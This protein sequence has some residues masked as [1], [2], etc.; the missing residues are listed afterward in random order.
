M[1][2]VRL[3]VRSCSACGHDHVDLSFYCFPN[4]PLWVNSSPYYW[5][6]ICP[7]TGETIVSDYVKP[8]EKDLKDPRITGPAGPR[9]SNPI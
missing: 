7:K 5:G 6:A 1:E 2:R 8:E 3:N 9:E 4:G